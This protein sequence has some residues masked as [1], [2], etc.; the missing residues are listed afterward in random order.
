MGYSLQNKVEE[1][2]IDILF[3]LENELEIETGKIPEVHYVNKFS[4]FENLG[5]SE[6]Y[7]KEFEYAKNYFSGIVYT[8]PLIIIS[9]SRNLDILSEEVGHFLHFSHINFKEKTPIGRFCFGAISEML[10]FFSSKLINSK[11]KNRYSNYENKLQ[12]KFKIQEILQ[13]VHEEYQRGEKKF[14][15]LIYTQGYSMGEKLFNSYILKLL[16][17]NKIKN[18][19]TNPLE[20]EEEALYQFLHWKYEVLK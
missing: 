13:T 18:I 8:N 2:V 15:D 6:E 10:G 4:K 16:S 7:K 14:E 1:K 17:K 5:L 11:V 3:E 19:F 20:T 9:G 12:N